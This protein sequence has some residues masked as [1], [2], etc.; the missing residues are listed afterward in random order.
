[1]KSV[2]NRAA[3][4]F[5]KET[6]LCTAGI[7]A[8]LSAFFVPPSLNYI[9]YLDF[10]VLALLFCL[11]LVVAG[12]QSIGV[13]HFLGTVLLRGI[14]TTRQLALLL[15]LLCFFSSMLITNDVSLLTFVPFAVMI[16]TLAGQMQICIPVIVLQTIAAN[17]GSM[18]TPVGNPQNLYLY[19]AFSM[20][21]GGFLK[22]MLPLTVLSLALLCAAVF[23]LPSKR[24]R[25][26]EL[27]LPEPVSRQKLVV[28]AALFLVCLGCVIHLLS[29]LVMLGIV[30][31]VIGF[32]DR[33]LLK[34][35]DYY[36]L[37]TFVFFFLFIGNME[38][39]P[40]VSDLLRRLIGGHELLFGV[41]LSQCISNVPSAILLSGFTNQ[42][43]PLLYG[44]NIGGL[45]TLI[46]SLASLISYRCYSN[47]TGA[48]VKSYFKTFT[49]Y[50]LVF[51]I[52]MVPAAVCLLR[53]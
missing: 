53:L 18:F 8:V 34:K 30:V 47:V 24:L 39:I 20:T 5:R 10:R 16:L 7:L 31:I 35:A 13:F 52:L 25:I 15:I 49:V 43:V 17:L 2:L 36:L 3:A 22:T 6:V 14:K 27:N 1:M 28:Y 12:M 29:Y 40:A 37:L 19:S 33:S 26:G 48:Q 44:V 32:T 38:R 46:A 9:S 11:M 45:G 21:M 42:A 4:F 23:F 41:L 51:L 50:N